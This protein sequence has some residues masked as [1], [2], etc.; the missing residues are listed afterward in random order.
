M[1]KAEYRANDV[2][3]GDAGHGILLDSV[4]AKRAVFASCVLRRREYVPV[5]SSIHCKAKDLPFF[6]S[7]LLHFLVYFRHRFRKIVLRIPQ[8]VHEASH[9][10]SGDFAVVE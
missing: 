2:R 9:R 6:P 1:T 7:F 3:N 5:I 8:I 10:M 4:G